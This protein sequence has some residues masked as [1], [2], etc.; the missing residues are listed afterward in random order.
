MYGRPRWSEA[1]NY[2]L[3][4]YFSLIY[5][6][7]AFVTWGFG[8]RPG[9]SLLASVAVVLVCAITF[10]YGGDS[11][12]FGKF[13]DSLYF[14]MV[15]FVT[16]GYG[17]ISQ[18]VAIYKIFSAAEAFLGMVLMGLFLAGYASKAKQY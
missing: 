14:S 9:R 3:K 10:Y 1:L 12:T 11:V 15:T 5:E 18:K 8:E 2:V 7:F 16:L 6:F 17:D 4:S 13:A